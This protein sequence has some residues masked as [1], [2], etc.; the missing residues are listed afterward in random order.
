MA[1][2]PL[3]AEVDEPAD[4]AQL[5]GAVGNTAG[6]TSYQLLT[7]KKP[8]LTL[9]RV[10]GCMVQFMIPEQQRSGKLAPKAH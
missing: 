3:L 2:V 5:L 4:G 9:A 8:D 10:W 6:T 1:T 7:G